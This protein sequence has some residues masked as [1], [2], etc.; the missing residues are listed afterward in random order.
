M[1][2]AIRNY[3]PHRTVILSIC[4]LLVVVGLG[5]FALSRMAAA[6]PA[7]ISVTTTVDED[8]HPA[9]G[10][11]CSIYEAS[12]A[13]NTAAA[14]GGCSAGDAVEGSVIQVP[15]GAYPA[16]VD[17]NGD[18]AAIILDDA[19][20]IGAG[21]TT[22]LQGYGFSLQGDLAKELSNFTLAS[23]PLTPTVSG[24][25]I[26]IP[27]NNKTVQNI[28]L[29]T[30]EADQ[31]YLDIYIGEFLQ[32]EQSNVTIDTIVTSGLIGGATITCEAQLC[33]NPI[34]R[35]VEFI[36]L[37]NASVNLPTA[38][39]ATVDTI[40]LTNDFTASVNA[41]FDA[42]VTDVTLTTTSDSGAGRFDTAG[43][44][45][46]DGV[47]MI[48]QSTN[49]VNMRT[50]GEATSMT[51]ITMTGGL[52]AQ[53]N[54]LQVQTDTN[55]LT[56]V[57]LTG[58][59]TSIYNYQA[60]GVIDGVDARAGEGNS[61]F[62]VD[63]AEIRN[64]T[65]QTSDGGTSYLYN[66]TQGDVII[67]TITFEEL[68]A[69]DFGITASMAATDSTD[70]RNAKFLSLGEST[71]LAINSPEV[72]VEGL[73]VT[74]AM[75]QLGGTTSTATLGSMSLIGSPVFNID[76]SAI[77]GSL[78]IEDSYMTDAQGG[79]LV[80]GAGPT[81]SFTLRNSQIDNLTGA[82][83]PKAILSTDVNAVTIDASTIS[84]IGSPNYDNYAIELNGGTAHTI[85]NTTIE[86]TTGSVSVFQQ[87]GSAPVS[88]EMRHVTIYN[89]GTGSPYGGPGFTAAILAS[90]GDPGGVAIDVTNSLIVGEDPYDGCIVSS[91]AIL[92]ATTSIATNADCVDFGFTLN[93]QNIELLLSDTLSD[94]DSEGA[95]L[96][97]NTSP[98]Y[99]QTLGLPA[100]S[101][102]IGFGTLA[103]C[104]PTD[105]RAVVR[106]LSDG[107]D[108]GAV[109]YV[110]PAPVVP[111]PPTDQ[112]SGGTPQP[113]GTGTT[114]AS[115]R[116]A[117]TQG[118]QNAT[119]TETVQD[120]QSPED[121]QPTT[122]LTPVSTQNDSAPE[123]E[124]PAEAALPLWAVIVGSL[125]VVIVSALGYRAVVIRR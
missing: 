40:S 24:L 23:V 84:T 112:G 43:A 18:R 83:G 17:I 102:A 87:S 29:N 38:N 88:L 124:T 59:S 67:D 30:T 94:D 76:A 80:S 22:I 115:S 54:S 16:A 78:L 98:R 10:T 68:E 5:T 79:I 37:F 93:D 21:V 66:N 1:R 31:F 113:A 110:A 104:L 12:V 19:S 106:V 26:D 45:V 58:Y 122:E 44:S 57:S 63:V 13:A 121:V 86:Y 114:T 25:R 81:S 74:N 46:V 105:A 120:Q 108:V 64:V 36:S 107:C 20:L 2:V 91:D 72:V 47:M 48:D 71:G 89:P 61:Y 92:T 32:T 96:G 49:G 15:A 6:A 90:A 27:G 109:E 35:N 103:Q 51:N 101:D 69:S 62:Y 117:Q 85:Q 123:D 77:S 65:S 60:G 28:L 42:Q 7:I 97:Y 3:A 55:S 119:T 75:L 50:N 14:Y 56:N 116:I 9:A 41:G 11:G 73:H 111:A 52:A 125:I 8:S 82:F 95:A 53:D 4:A 70:L 34:V 99:L 100:G 33:T 39:G 118:L